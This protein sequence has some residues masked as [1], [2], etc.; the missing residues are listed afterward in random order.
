MY[1]TL[2]IV[3]ILHT[4]QSLH[5]FTSC[6][7]LQYMSVRIICAKYSLC[8]STSC[9][10]AIY[11]RSSTSCYFMWKCLFYTPCT[12]YT[13]SLHMLLPSTCLHESFAR[14]VYIL[15]LH[16]TISSTVVLL[17]HATSCYFMWQCHLQYLQPHATFS[18]FLQ[19]QLR[20]LGSQ[21]STSEASLQPQQSSMQWQLRP[22]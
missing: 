2:H 14:T 12:A 18:T 10:N 7:S 9:D 16:V 21:F 13:H 8:S 4:L 19:W 22:H 1:T 20:F 11:C 15:L 6:A 5:T 17:L 3:H